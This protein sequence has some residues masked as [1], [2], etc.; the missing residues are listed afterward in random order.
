MTY[1]RIYDNSREEIVSYPLIE[2]SHIG[3]AQFS[4]TFP[5]ATGLIYRGEGGG[6]GSA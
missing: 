2:E 5:G 3:Y 6:L 4:R 1:I